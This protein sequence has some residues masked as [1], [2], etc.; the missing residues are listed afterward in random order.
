VALLL[1][2]Q[3]DGLNFFLNYFLYLITYL[4]PSHH[5]ISPLLAVLPQPDP[6]AGTRSKLGGDAG[7]KDQPL[8]T[9]KLNL[10]RCAQLPPHQ[11]SRF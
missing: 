3:F 7:K 5:L 2:F 4:Q 9:T 11:E 10:N 1:A 6:T 8:E